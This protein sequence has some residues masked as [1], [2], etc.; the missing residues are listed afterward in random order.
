MIKNVNIDFFKKSKVKLCTI[1]MIGAILTSGLVG[2]TPHK[3]ASPPTDLEIMTEEN[4]AEINVDFQNSG[5]LD[6]EGDILSFI[7]K[8]TNTIVAAVATDSEETNTYVFSGKEYYI[9]S[10]YLPK[11]EFKVDD[12]NQEFNI[13]ADY[14]T[15]EIKIEEKT[16]TNNIQK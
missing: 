9:I 5:L 10:E 3:E 4:T 7:T 15:N 2:C 16:N 14:A 11:T 8:D 13:T 1:G 6:E 12:A